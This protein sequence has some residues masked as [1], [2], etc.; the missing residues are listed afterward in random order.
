M[1]Q[2]SRLHRLLNRPTFL[3]PEVFPY[4]D[5]TIVPLTAGPVVDIA[6]GQVLEETHYCPICGGI[7][8]P[9]GTNHAPSCEV[10]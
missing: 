10:A 2:K 7:V 6:L 3:Q 9:F 5:V 1:S 4:V 8:S